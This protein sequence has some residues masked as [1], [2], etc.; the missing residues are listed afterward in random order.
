[1]ILFFN[2]RFGI[3]SFRKYTKSFIEKH[4]NVIKKYF[5][6]EQNDGMI[7]QSKEYY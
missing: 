5:L 1:M 4:K 6:E 2:L 3:L 7:F